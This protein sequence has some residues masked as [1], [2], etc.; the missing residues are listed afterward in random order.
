M[1]ES[2]ITPQDVFDY[3][4]ADI[5][6]DYR[7]EQVDRQIREIQSRGLC[8]T[9]WMACTVFEIAWYMRSMEML[10][11][12]FVDNQEFAEALLD[13]ITAKR[14]TQARRYA[15]LGADVVCLG[16][17]VAS[18]RGMLMSAAMWRRWLK[19]RLA[20]V[21]A[22][23]KAARPDV[24]VLYH[25][26]GD[27]TSII[28]D[29]IEIGVDILNPVQPEC[30]DPVAIKKKYG[31]R[32]SFWGTIGTQTTMPFGTP[33]DVRRE[34]CARIETVGKG[35]GLLIAPTHVVEP[36]VPWENILAFAEAVKEFGRY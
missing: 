29:L 6:A 5:E 18:Q 22:A 36:E 31:E 13:R 23:A 25:S 10:L 9:A 19:P 17:D 3:P 34:I 16:D 8:A 27:V 28:L 33:E 2:E 32:L 1:I 12:D 26:Y 14:E 11:M 7:Y 20:R 24:L 4:L 30:M 21:V 35:G 15:E